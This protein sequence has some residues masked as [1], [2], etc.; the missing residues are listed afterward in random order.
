L[1]L[2]WTHAPQEMSNR[3]TITISPRV[4]P[5]LSGSGGSVV[6]DVNDLR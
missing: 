6:T 1:G 4:T 3:Y 2:M 5:S